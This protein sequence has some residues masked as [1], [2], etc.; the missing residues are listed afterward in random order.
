MNKNTCILLVIII[1]FLLIL[2]ICNILQSSSK[3][4]NEI[5]NFNVLSEIPLQLSIEEEEKI[6][7]EIA[8]KTEEQ[9][10]KI[11]NDYNQVNNSIKKQAEIYNK[12]F[13]ESAKKMEQQ[14]NEFN[15][16]VEKAD[17][18]ASLA[19]NIVSELQ[20]K[21]EIKIVN[22]EKK[23]IKMI[24]DLL[25]KTDKEL[26]KQE[27]IRKNI[28]KKN[29]EIYIKKIYIEAKAYQDAIEMEEKYNKIN[30]LEELNRYKAEELL[31][32]Q[33]TKIKEINQLGKIVNELDKKENNDTTN[34][35][36][37]NK[38]KNI[39][40]SELKRLLNNFEDKF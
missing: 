25:K 36:N 2:I 12:N 24:E 23:Q 5:D 9:I 18:Q 4:Y 39:L 16:M 34:N 15:N 40:T 31:I 26:E 19:S 38:N 8:K 1:I 7:R 14:F 13:L 27:N 11:D 35:P 33:E 22:E 30:V 17:K 37:I 21:E 10:K 28:E 6:N 32:E 29:Q 3:C 20:K